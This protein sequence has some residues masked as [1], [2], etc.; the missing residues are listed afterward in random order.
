MQQ[1]LA[2]AVWDDDPTVTHTSALDDY[3]CAQ[4]NAA[5]AA[6]VAAPA[7]HMQRSVHRQ[8]LELRAPQIET[9]HDQPCSVKDALKQRAALLSV[10]QCSH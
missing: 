4:Q 1:V 2:K 8:A 9:M 6:D 7:P 3:A 5:V 10:V